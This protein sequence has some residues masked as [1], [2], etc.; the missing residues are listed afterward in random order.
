M[1][2]HDGRQLGSDPTAQVCLVG[3]DQTS[4]PPHRIQDQRAIQRDQG[5]RVDDLDIEPV[6]VASIDDVPAMRSA[7]KQAMQHGNPVIPTPTREA[8][9]KPAVVLKYANLKAW[10]AFERIAELWTISQRDGRYRITR[11]RK[12]PDRGWEDDPAAVE[13]LPPA[14][15]QDEVADRLVQLLKQH[16]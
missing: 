7:L 14:C 16:R 15:G 12:A 6:G 8:L 11:G 3:H 9:S 10:W 4:G 1:L 13:N 2:G 5:P